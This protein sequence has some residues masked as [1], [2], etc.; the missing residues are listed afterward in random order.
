VVVRSRV[1][2]ENGPTGGPAFTDVLGVLETWGQH[3]IVIRR[4][5]DTLIEIDIA[6]IVSGKVVPPAPKRR[7]RD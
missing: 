3:S 1:P 7:T 6:L 5:D 4:G 2:G